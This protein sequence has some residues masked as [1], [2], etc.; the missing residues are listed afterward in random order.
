LYVSATAQVTTLTLEFELAILYLRLRGCV[1]DLELIHAAK[2]SPA[3][4]LSLPQVRQFQVSPVDK[5]VPCPQ[6]Y[7]Q[8]RYVQVVGCSRTHPV[9]C[10]GRQKHWPEIQ[11]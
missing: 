1:H 10:A 2:S 8:P 5:P 3:Q 7:S 11:G 9:H 4:A 6:H